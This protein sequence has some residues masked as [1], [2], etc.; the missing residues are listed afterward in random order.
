MATVFNSLN[1]QLNQ[2]VL[3]ADPLV[4]G[5]ITITSTGQISESVA[6]TGMLLVGGA[7]EVLVNGLLTATA[8]GSRG[9]EFGVAA[10]ASQISNLT[11]RASGEVLG[12]DY[13]V[14]A[15]HATNITNSGLIQGAN[16][17]YVAGGGV[18]YT[19]TNDGEIIASAGN[20][21]ILTDGA[22]A[23]AISNSDT[24]TG[25]IEGS[26]SSDSV[27][28]ITNTGTLNGQIWARGGNDS[29]NNAGLINDDVFLDGGDDSLINTGTIS[30]DINGWEGADT[31]QNDG[32]LNGHLLSGQDNDTIGNTGT[33]NGDV[34]AWLG[35]DSFT[36]SGL[37]TGWIFMGEGNDTL[38]GG[39]SS[40]N[41]ADEAGRD[42]YALRRR[43]RQFRCG[44]RW[45]GHQPRRCQ[46][47]LACRCLTHDW[48]L[49][50]RL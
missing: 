24:I 28:T 4:S 45:H 6:Q 26:F 38:V 49:W 37:V 12:V 1:H 29:I 40:E 23:H 11:V 3:F 35:N 2:S 43:H 41:V 21:A 27:E 44:W 9:L 14:I 8:P 16:G 10:T 20:A 7:Y 33:I 25:R 50:R 15:F 18:A 34:N 22:G 30:G 42:N 13:G 19:I 48:H 31:I 32:T 17:I 5:P 46:W 36:N 39:A 47:W